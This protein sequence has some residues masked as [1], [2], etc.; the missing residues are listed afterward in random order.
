MD[1]DVIPPECIMH[2]LKFVEQKDLFR[3]SLS[4]RLF[5]GLWPHVNRIL[6]VNEQNPID[7]A[8][9]KTKNIL[10]FKRKNFADFIEYFPN[11]QHAALVGCKLR[12]NNISL[13]TKAYKRTLIHLNISENP[14][15]TIDGTLS[16]IAAM[17]NLEHLNVSDCSKWQDSSK[18]LTEDLGS[19]YHFPKSLKQFVISNLKF[20]TF[21]VVCDILVK[22]SL[23]YV[24]ATHLLKPDNWSFPDFQVMVSLSMSNAVQYANHAYITNSSSFAEIAL[25][26]LCPDLKTVDECVRRGHYSIL[27]LM[28][29]LINNISLPAVIDCIM[30]NHPIVVS[31]LRILQYKNFDK[32]PQ[33]V[34]DAVVERG[35]DNVMV[36]LR[37][38][39]FIDR[40]V[41]ENLSIESIR[42]CFLS[43][44]KNMMEHLVDLNL[45]EKLNQIPVDDVHQVMLN[46]YV[47]AFR[48]LINAGYSQ[49]N[50]ID[51]NVLAKT[52]NVE[53]YSQY[54]S[55][56]SNAKY[57][58]LGQLRSVTTHV[59]EDDDKQDL[60]ENSSSHSSDNEVEKSSK[61]KK[62][63]KKQKRSRKLK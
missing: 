16:S 61:N 35:L 5:S 50:D 10:A 23:D 27:A 25:A 9:G 21:F 47:N 4:S 32:L 62:K 12:D 37:K 33:H 30:D 2:I 54:V 18:I 43:G 59:E 38:C 63:K 7:K 51:V 60:D 39:R 13:L 48:H 22:S 3:V 52:S 28:P 11:I 53:G 55:I 56:L 41:W 31:A 17:E 6:S 57:E 26:G 40:S 44:K 15:I 46:N 58:K 34:F 42:K 45:I 49:I 29:S 19:T 20:I 8:M 36:E 14:L 1:L 24:L